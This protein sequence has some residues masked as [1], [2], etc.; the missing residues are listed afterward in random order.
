MIQPLIAEVERLRQVMAEHREYLSKTESAT[1]YAVI[2][3]LLRMLGWNVHDAASVKPE[4]RAGATNTTRVDYALLQS[5]EAVA[6]IEAKPLDTK[7]LEKE[8][9]QLS[10]YCVNCQ[11]K[12]VQ[13]GILTNG[14]EWILID[15]FRVKLPLAERVAQR[16]VVSH[17]VPLAALQELVSL[18]GLISGQAA[19]ATVPTVTLAHQPRRG[20]L[21]APRRQPAASRWRRCWTWPGLAPRSRLCCAW[22]MARKCLRGTGQPC[23]RRSSNGSSGL[24]T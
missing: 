9:E 16:F 6:L 18:F 22:Q 3:P 20:H 8:T 23:S 15:A 13:W 11:P 4:Y 14:D 17:G 21:P 10:N 24:V 2:D 1:R 5:S 7:L 19:E 12:S